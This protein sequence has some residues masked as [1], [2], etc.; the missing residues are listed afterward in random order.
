[1]R[2]YS[3]P[4]SP[5]HCPQCLL[6]HKNCLCHEVEVIQPLFEVLVIRHHSEIHKPSGTVRLIDMAL[7]ERCTV[8]DWDSRMPDFQLQ[9]A[10]P[11]R[12]LLLFPP[13]GEDPAQYEEAWQLE[14]QPPELLVVLDGTWRQ[15]RRMLR[16]I[17]G[18]RELPRLSLPPPLRPGIRLRTPPHPWAMPTIE[19]LARA[20]EHLEGP[21]GTPKAE[22]LDRLFATLMQ[23]LQAPT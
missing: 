4:D 3:P 6:L 16:R 20:I 8:E 13:D 22:A 5:A 21:K 7:G 2:S 12:S 23:R 18:L 17:K 1:M 14:H 19:A 10:L 15:A 9:T 11:T